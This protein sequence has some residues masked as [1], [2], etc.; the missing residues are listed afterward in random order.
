M[1]QSN[2]WKKLKFAAK[3]GQKE[4]L[5]K[6]E[7]EVEEDVLY[8]ILAAPDPSFRNRVPQSKTRSV[9]WLFWY[10]ASDNTG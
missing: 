5:V 2:T 3:F 6:A 1:K 7:P 9:F 4:A 10:A 8:K